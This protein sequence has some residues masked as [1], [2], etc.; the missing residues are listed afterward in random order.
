MKTKAFSVKQS[1]VVAFKKRRYARLMCSKAIKKGELK[2]D[3]ECHL[4]KKEKVDIQAHHIDYGKPLEVV[5][6][7]TKCHGIAHCKGHALN[8]DN[9][10]QTP[11][12]AL[13][14]RYDAVTVTVYIPLANYLAIKEQA[15]QQNLSVSKLLR[16]DMVNLYPLENNQLEF[17]FGVKN[18]SSQVQDERVSDMATNEKSLLFGERESIS[19]VRSEGNSSLP[20][21]EKRLLPIYEGY[22][23]TAGRLHRDTAA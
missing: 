22:G 17:N 19:Q 11:M 15:E 10:K 16:D 12:P 14:D 2:P 23:T 7:C 8:P 3:K 4:C 18:A 5:W 21:M 1:D 20:R 6:L 9:N 13:F